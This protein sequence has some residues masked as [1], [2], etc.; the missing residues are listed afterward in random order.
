MEEGARGGRAR[1]GRIGP[2]PQAAGPHV[3]G[4][5]LPWRPKGPAPS[6]EVLSCLLL[7]LPARQQGPDSSHFMLPQDLLPRGLH[8]RGHLSPRLQSR[9]KV[10]RSSNEYPDSRLMMRIYRHRYVF[11]HT[12]HGSAC[13]T[14]ALTKGPNLRAPAMSLEF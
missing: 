6:S 11:G 8:A 13:R 10:P 9:S 7:C 4:G 3:Q 2:S 12:T 5:L 1:S 14:L